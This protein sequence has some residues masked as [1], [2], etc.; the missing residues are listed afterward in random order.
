MIP[1]L[2]R[3]NNVLFISKEATNDQIVISNYAIMLIIVI[4]RRRERDES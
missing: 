1:I 4:V 3:L 2:F